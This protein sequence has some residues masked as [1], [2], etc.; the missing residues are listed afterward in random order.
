[1][2][3]TELLFDS[4]PGAPNVVTFAVRVFPETESVL[5][6]LSPDD[7]RPARCDG[8]L[9]YVTMVT[10]AGRIFVERLSKSSWFEITIV[11]SKNLHAVDAAG[12]IP[13]TIEFP[14]KIKEKA[15]MAPLEGPT[16]FAHRQSMV[17]GQ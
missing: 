14:K 16:G 12:D 6:S 10:D 7:P 11:A 9:T 2:S 8:S 5:V 3:V 15:K 4:A 1:M 17:S 13:R